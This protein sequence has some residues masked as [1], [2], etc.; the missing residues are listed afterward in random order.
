MGKVESVIMLI[1]TVVG[2]P[3]CIFGIVKETKEQVEDYIYAKQYNRC[4][5]TMAHWRGVLQVWLVFILVL[6]GIIAF[7][8]WF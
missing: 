2:I 3:L 6:F 5:D 1:L 7:E 4:I 8:V